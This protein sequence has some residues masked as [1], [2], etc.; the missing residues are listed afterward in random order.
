MINSYWKSYFLFSQKEVKGIIALGVILFGSVLLSLLFPSTNKNRIQEQMTSARHLS[1]FDPNL[2]DSAKAIELGIPE[3]QVRSLLHYRQKG[4]YFK[5]AAD[6]AKLY[7]LTPVLYNS[8]KPFI[9]MQ[10]A[11]LNNQY[12]SHYKSDKATKYFEEEVGWE[13]DINKADENDWL[14][15][16]HLSLPTIRRIMAYKN[17]LGFY[18]NVHQISK[19]YGVPDSAY[20]LIRKHLRVHPSMQYLLNA[21]AMQFNDWKNLGMFTD[22][23]IWNILKLKKENGGRLGWEAIVE[24]CDLSEVEAMA[25]RNKVRLSD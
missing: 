19:V 20:Q 6:F 9:R 23:Q 12:V 25:L 16:S 24:S 4:G 17:Y 11:A 15:K 18:S 22:K 21:S 10:A 1:Y 5:N 14:N 8:L 3:K 13:I 7:G 2:V